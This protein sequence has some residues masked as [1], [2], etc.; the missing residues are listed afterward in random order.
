MARN[1][2]VSFNPLSDQ[3]IALEKERLR[4]GIGRLESSNNYQALG[5]VLERKSGTDRAYGKYQVM[6]ANIP[7]WTEQALGKRLTPQQFLASPEAQ[8][9]VFDQQMTQNLKKYGSAQDAASVWFSGRPLGWAERAGARDVNMGVG[10]YVAKALGQPAAV[11]GEQVAGGDEELFRRL[12]ARAA[13]RLNPQ[14][15]VAPSEMQGA[16]TEGGPAVDPFVRL[17][18]RAAQRLAP[19]EAPKAPPPAPPAPPIQVQAPGLPQDEWG[20]GKEFLNAVTFGA[21]PSVMAATGSPY[22]TEQIQQMRKQYE[23]EYPYRSAAAEIGG[24]IAQ[25]VGLMLAGPPVAGAVLGSRALQAIPAIQ[26]IAPVIQRMAAMRP[27]YRGPFPSGGYVAESGLPAM[28]ARTAAGGVAGAAKGATQAALNVGVHPDIPAEEQVKTGA[29]VGAF[30]EPAMR[31]LTGAAGPTMSPRIEESIRD[32]GKMAQSKY[33]VNLMPWQLSNMPAE[34]AIASKLLTP[35]KAVDQAKQFSKAFGK[36]FKHSDV[37]TPAK[38]SDSIDRIGN[39][40]DTIS[41]RTRIDLANANGRHLRREIDDLVDEILNDVTDPAT[42][43]HLLRTVQNMDTKLFQRP[44]RGEVIQNLTQKDGTIDKNLSPK[45]NSLYQYYN[46]RLKSIVY[47]IF[48]RADPSD[49]A[50]WDATKQEYKAALIAAKSA[51]DAGILDPKRVAKQAQKVR[52]S[53]DMGELAKIGDKMFSI[54]SIGTPQLPPAARGERFFDQPLVQ[55]LGAGAFPLAAGSLTELGSTALNAIGMSP[56]AAAAGG[57]LLAGGRY[58]SAKAFEALKN[59]MLTS[60]T[61]QRAI[62]A[63][64]MPMMQ[65]VLTGPLAVSGS[66]SGAETYKGR[67]R[68]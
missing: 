62:M 37:L 41:L 60:P 31:Y 10:Q 43:T 21:V 17:Q 38:I 44:L 30:A 48:H 47:D 1:Y 6:G 51:T 24:G 5:P 9:A 56:L 68:K 36:L 66:V 35:E 57:A 3:Q 8:E 28:A 61:Y 22:T 67:R 65:N 14:A 26:R 4:R 49:A 20:A 53:G 25:G 64:E 18:Q 42:Q 13:A 29:A 59:K 63:G 7:S 46:G 32:I 58:G 40:F 54:S 15:G 27:G 34:Q 55:V 12:Q 45:T 23:K 2:G 50:E 39:V 16:V 33:G 52:A 11:Q 19:I